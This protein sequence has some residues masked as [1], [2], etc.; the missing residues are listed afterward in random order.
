VRFGTAAVV[1]A[2]ALLG[3]ASMASDTPAQVMRGGC[4]L[5]REG[6]VAGSDRRD[7][8][9]RAAPGVLGCGPRGA[10][11]AAGVLE[12]R[13]AGGP[14]AADQSHAAAQP[15]LAGGAECRRWTRSVS[16]VRENRM[17]GSMRRR[18]E[19]RCKWPSTPM[20]RRLPPPGRRP[21]Q[22]RFRRAVPARPGSALASDRAKAVAA[23]RLVS[24][25]AQ[26]FEPGLQRSVAALDRLCAWWLGGAD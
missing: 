11:R 4:P 24:G 25:F 9:V 17:P 7:R 21:S 18:E 22:F 23:R 16:R 3:A 10:A 12:R 8:G 19:S 20:A 6:A 1:L 5:N 15:A 2:V 26:L 14:K 13:R